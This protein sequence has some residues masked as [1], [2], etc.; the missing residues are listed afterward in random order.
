VHVVIDRLVKLITMKLLP[1]LFVTRLSTRVLLSLTCSFDLEIEKFD[2]VT[3]FLNVDIDEYIYMRPPLGLNIESQ[4]GLKMV[5]K[6][7]TSLYGIK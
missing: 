3:E 7:N 2:V 4:N 1:P 6:L 5:C